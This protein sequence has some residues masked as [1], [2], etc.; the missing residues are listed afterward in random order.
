MEIKNTLTAEQ[1]R[2]A[3]VDLVLAREDVIIPL[4]DSIES[5][6]ISRLGIE[7]NHTEVEVKAKRLGDIELVL[8]KY[9][10]R[11]SPKL[12]ESLKL[13]VE[14]GFTAKTPDDPKNFNR[15]VYVMGRWRYEHYN[16]GSNG[17]DA[18]RAHTVINTSLPEYRDEYHFKIS[19]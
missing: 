12:F 2:S 8:T 14:I 10:V 6:I 3:G 19:I 17:C 13:V 9:A 5:K 4:I 1:I 16:G 11:Q 7:A 15:E 18:F